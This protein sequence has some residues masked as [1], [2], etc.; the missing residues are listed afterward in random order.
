M[1]SQALSISVLAAL[2]AHPG[3]ACGPSGSAMTQPTNNSTSSSTVTNQRKLTPGRERAS[4]KRIRVVKQQLREYQKA[5]NTADI[6]DLM[7]GNPFPAEPSREA[8]RRHL[9]NKF[10]YLALKAELG[11]ATTAEVMEMRRLQHTLLGH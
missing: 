6:M 8:Q 2:L 3:L 7:Q 10:E 1:K 9:I 5:Q 11:H 4:R